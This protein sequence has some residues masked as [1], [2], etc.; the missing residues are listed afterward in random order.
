MNLSPELLAHA[1]TIFPSN[2]LGY[3]RLVSCIERELDKL[4]DSEKSEIKLLREIRTDV[5]VLLQQLKPRLRWNVIIRPLEP[6]QK[7]RPKMDT[8]KLGQIPLGQ[9]L[10]VDFVPDEKVDVKSDGKFASVTILDGD[11]TA[12]IADGSTDSSWRAYFNGDGAIGL[13]SAEVAADGHVGDGDVEVTQRVEWEVISKDA[14]SFTATVGKLEP[15]PT[16]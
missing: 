11:S 12:Q 14:T 3:H 4:L 1:K 9:R 16:A 10:P 13:K 15:I 5:R 6:I 2:T 7:E 8:L